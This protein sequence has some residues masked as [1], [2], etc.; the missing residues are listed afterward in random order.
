MIKYNKNVDKITRYDFRSDSL[1]ISVAKAFQA[2][3]LKADQWGTTGALSAGWQ[4]PSQ[5]ES[6]QITPGSIGDLPPQTI[7]AKYGPCD[8]TLWA[9][10]MVCLAPAVTWWQVR[11]CWFGCHWFPHQFVENVEIMLNTHHLENPWKI[12]YANP[13]LHRKR[14]RPILFSVKVLLQG[15]ANRNLPT[16]CRAAK[17]SPTLCDQNWKVPGI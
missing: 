16:K 15:R 7:L 3:T 6:H 5:A 11:P 8:T 17:P 10:C 13:E 9:K 12:Q 4:S 14:P 1:L 2:R